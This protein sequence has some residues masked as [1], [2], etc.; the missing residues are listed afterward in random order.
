[1]SKDEATPEQL[2]TIKHNMDLV[3]CFG[4]MRALRRDPWFSKHLQNISIDM[5]GLHYFIWKKGEVGDEPPYMYKS[6]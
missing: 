4:F 1:M 5:I 3:V 6:K 2:E